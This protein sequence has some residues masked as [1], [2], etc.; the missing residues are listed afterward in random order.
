[1]SRIDEIFDRL[2]STSPGPWKGSLSD[3]FDIQD[4]NG[5]T[6]AKLTNINNSNTQLTE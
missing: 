5:K 4:G 6:I 2:D 3:T 1:M